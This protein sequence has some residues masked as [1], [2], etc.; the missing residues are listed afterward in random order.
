M[1]RDYRGVQAGIGMMAISS[2]VIQ[3]PTRDP[4]SPPRL[5]MLP[6][7]TD[8]YLND[9]RG[10]SIEEHGAYLMLLM[11][12]WRTVG[13]VI[14]NDDTRICRMLGITARKW[15][16]LKPVVMSFWTLGA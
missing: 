9:T 5:P 15:A 10:L 11:L 7:W 12:A 2:N 4:A 6:L 8:S 1:P 13:G 3:L 16:K 14:P